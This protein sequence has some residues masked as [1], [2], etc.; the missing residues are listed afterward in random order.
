MKSHIIKSNVQQHYRF[1]V[2]IRVLLAA[3]GGFCVANLSVAVVGLLFPD[4]LAVATY[5]GFL[6]SFIVWLVFILAIFSI[7]KTLNTVWLCSGALLSLGCLVSV[8]KIWG[9]T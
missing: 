3:F 1:I 5:A 4:N 8:L 7:K 6:L 2:L 9:S